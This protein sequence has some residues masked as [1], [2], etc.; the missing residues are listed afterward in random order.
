MGKFNLLE[1][2][3]EKK[4]SEDT[5]GLELSFAGLLWVRVNLCNLWA[6]GC[7]NSE[8]RALSEEALCN[9]L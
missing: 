7:S 2:Y 4:F 8:S 3:F 1:N 9:P 6:F 5:V